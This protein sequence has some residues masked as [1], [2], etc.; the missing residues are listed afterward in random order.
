MKGPTMELP[1]N[2]VDSVLTILTET[3]R[4]K[5]RAALEVEAHQLYPLSPA[6]FYRALELAGVSLPRIESSVE[7]DTV[8]NLDGRKRWRHRQKLVG[9]TPTT[10]EYTT[11]ELVINWDKFKNQENYGL[12]IAVSTE[13]P[14]L[15]TTPPGPVTMQRIKQLVSFRAPNADYRYD[16]SVVTSTAP[17]AKSVITYE[18]EVEI[19]RLTKEALAKFGSALHLLFLYVYDSNLPYPMR[20]R[21]DFYKSFNARIGGRPFDHDIDL[22][23]ITQARNLT[24]ADMVYG[25]L[26]PM[27]PLQP[28]QPKYTEYFGTAKAE[29]NRVFLVLEDDGVWL[30]SP[31]ERLNLVSRGKSFTVPPD[32]VGSIF[33]AEEIPASKRLGTMKNYT[34]IWLL[35]T[36][37][38]YTRQNPNLRFDTLSDRTPLVEGV[39]VQYNHVATSTPMLGRIEDIVNYVQATDPNNPSLSIGAKKYVRCRTVDEFYASMKYLLDILPALPYVTDGLVFTP[40][41]PYLPPKAKGKKRNLT[42]ITDV[43]KWKP[44]ALNTFDLLYSGG[45]LLAG[46]PERS[47]APFHPT[48]LLVSGLLSRVGTSPAVLADGL[49]YEI[50]PDAVTDVWRVHRPRYNKSRPNNVLTAEANWRSIQNPIEENTLRGLNLAKLRRYHNLEKR[51]LIQSAVAAVKASG[52]VTLKMLDIGTGAGGDLMKLGDFEEIIGIEPSD[53]N[54]AELAS[55][56]TEHPDIAQRIKIYPFKGQDTAAILAVLPRRVDVVSMM[57]SLTFFFESR[58]ILTQLINTIDGALGPNGRFIATVLDG[59]LTRAAF[60]ISPVETV[61]PQPPNIIGGSRLLIP[62]PDLEIVLRPDNHTVDI[63]LPGTIV[64]NQ[65]E[66]LTDMRFFT[67]L[68]AARGIVLETT[69]IL[70]GEKFLSPG[71]TILTRLYSAWQ[72]VRGTPTIPVTLVAPTPTTVHP[73][74]IPPTQ[75]VQQSREITAPP[76]APPV[77]ALQQLTLVPNPIVQMHLPPARLTSLQACLPLVDQETAVL[78]I[79]AFP[80]EQFRRIGCVGDRNNC[81]LHAILRGFDPKYLQYVQAGQVSD[82]QRALYT[83]QIRTMLAQQ[84]SPVEH[85]ALPLTQLDP[86]TWSLANLQSHLQSEEELDEGLLEYFGNKFGVAIY[87]F[88]CRTDDQAIQLVSRTVVPNRP[89]LLLFYNGNHYE[90]IETFRGNQYQTLMSA[91]DPLVNQLNAALG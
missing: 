1:E 39:D 52:A 29:G 23:A 80:R 26:I 91:S 53:I 84:L 22:D 46:G 90:T 70:D 89:V 25:G 41:A 35:L 76:P 12:R 71:E 37:V 55:R 7:T 51:L 19:V 28:G 74:V 66:F 15:T 31:P 72:Y 86:T 78:P 73:V 10:A 75:P 87:I 13:E 69:H 61:Q 3:K 11:K 34:G 14:S 9:G 20:R 38:L 33:E 85:A 2:L 79:A 4:S 5:P 56:L 81:M 65:T 44:R 57:M 68:L 49:V 40:N 47:L 64:Q 82:R 77:V 6:R 63:T 32:Y 27:L 8:V 54:R 36:D 83:R 59:A 45:Q 60:S 50:G 30:V 21:R 42:E 17:N 67:E 62:I 16:F 88:Q 24:A 18:I 48:E 43:V 58:E